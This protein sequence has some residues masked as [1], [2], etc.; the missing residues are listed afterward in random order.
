MRIIL[1]CSL[2]L[3]CACTPQTRG[4]V[5]SVLER[6]PSRPAYSGTPVY[7]SSQ[8]IGTN[9]MGECHGG[10]IGTPQAVCHGTMLNGQCTGAL[11]MP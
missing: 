3:V 6:L 2:A 4:K 11:L 10:I 7:S 5:L 8:C 9:I 1:I